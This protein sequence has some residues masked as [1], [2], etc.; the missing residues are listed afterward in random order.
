MRKVG[1]S[2]SVFQENKD[3]FPLPL[4]ISQK[5]W[6]AWLE[7]Y[8]KEETQVFEEFS[9]N[10]GHLKLTSTNGRVDEISFQDDLEKQMLYCDES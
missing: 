2:I 3:G 4:D 10:K 1:H 5:G 9:S 8:Q 7:G 6:K